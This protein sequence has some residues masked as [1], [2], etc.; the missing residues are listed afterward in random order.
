MPLGTGLSN[1]GHDA[2]EQY[3]QISD[4]NPMIGTVE[5]VKLLNTVGRSLLGLPE[6][7]GSEGRPGNIVGTY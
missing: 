3:F 6:I 7:F 5:R 1:L 4:G 2:F